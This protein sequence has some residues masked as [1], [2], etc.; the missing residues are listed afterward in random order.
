MMEPVA[1]IFGAGF[2]PPKKTVNLPATKMIQV[3]Q[4]LLL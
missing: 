4:Y 2:W 1:L 3:L